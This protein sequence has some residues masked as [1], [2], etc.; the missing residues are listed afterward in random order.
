[1][2]TAGPCFYCKQ[3]GLDKRA[4]IISAR[5]WG[6]EHVPLSRFSLEEVSQGPEHEYVSAFAIL[7][8][9]GG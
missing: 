2:P 6:L 7:R 4:R 9:P 5:E 1:M 3:G 8:L